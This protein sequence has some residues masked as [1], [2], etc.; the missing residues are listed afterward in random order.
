MEIKKIN[1]K[2]KENEVPDMM[3]MGRTKN[4]Y[5]L[6]VAKLLE[7]LDKNEIT[8]ICEIEDKKIK[9]KY[10]GRI[11]GAIKSLKPKVYKLISRDVNLYVKR[12]D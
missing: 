2:V 9:S 6:E 5:T 10:M 8:H 7:G 1:R 4:P 3:H 11:R 12:I